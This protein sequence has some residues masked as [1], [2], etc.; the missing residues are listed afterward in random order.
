MNPNGDKK[1][2]YM[3]IVSNM[4]ES[5]AKGIFSV[6]QVRAA[7]HFYD[8]NPHKLG[9]KQRLLT[10]YGRESCMFISDGLAYL[11]AR[12]PTDEDMESYPKVPP[13]PDGE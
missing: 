2:R 5:P 12:C 11:P 7:G 8:K 10:M 1:Y 13:P 3:V 9:G 4:L 6:N